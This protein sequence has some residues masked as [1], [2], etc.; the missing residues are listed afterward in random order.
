[1]QERRAQRLGVE[2]HAGA[3]LRDADRVGDELLARLAALVGVVLAREHERADDRVAV[4][5]L[6]D[7]VGVLLDDR[8][9][10]VDE[11]PLEVGELAG[12]GFQRGRGLAV[13]GTVDR[14]VRLDADGTVPLRGGQA[15]ALCVLLARNLRPSSSVCW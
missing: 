15:A 12:G 7:L 10:V 13:R 3:D 11:L 4:D 5:G 9:E 2:A 8:E 1:V 6:G 14:A